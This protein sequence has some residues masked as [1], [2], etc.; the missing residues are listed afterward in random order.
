MAH[1]RDSQSGLH[2]LRLQ[3]C[4]ETICYLEDWRCE[5]Q[6]NVEF[7]ESFQVPSGGGTYDVVI[8][9]LAEGIENN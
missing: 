8:R 9:I 3:L 1:K 6:R 5:R 2:G 7:H 4:A